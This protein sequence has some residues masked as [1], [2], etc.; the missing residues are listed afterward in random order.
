MG[1]HSAIEIQMASMKDLKR[2]LLLLA[3]IENIPYLTIRRYQKL[4]QFRYW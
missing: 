1:H 3:Q 2:E 4:V